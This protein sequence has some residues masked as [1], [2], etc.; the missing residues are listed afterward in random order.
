MTLTPKQIAQSYVLNDIII[1]ELILAALSQI[2]VDNYQ[3][4]SLI[5]KYDIIYRICTLVNRDELCA[6]F[7]I[8]NNE[9]LDIINTEYQNEI[10][11]LTNQINNRI[12]QII[13]N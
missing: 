7:E 5:S 13:S 6:F 2:E 12:N 11:N 4:Q 1:H 10:D 3:L 9:I 8:T